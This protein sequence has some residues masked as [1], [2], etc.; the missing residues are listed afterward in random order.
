M[1]WRVHDEALAHTESTDSILSIHSYED[2]EPQRAAR[3]QRY[4]PH[5]N[6]PTLATIYRRIVVE[7]VSVIE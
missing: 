3:E 2:S 6:L 4:S 5:D 7:G 1:G